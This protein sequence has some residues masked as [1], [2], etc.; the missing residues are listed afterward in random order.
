MTMRQKSCILPSLLDGSTGVELAPRSAERLSGH[1]GG[2]SGQRLRTERPAV[3]PP[4]QGQRARALLVGLHTGE[5]RTARALLDRRA[6]A[7]P[8]GGGPGPR[9]APSSATVT[10]TVAVADSIPDVLA[11][12][13][14]LDPAASDACTSPCIWWW[15]WP[16]VSCVFLAFVIVL[17]APQAERLAQI[18]LLQAW[19]RGL[20]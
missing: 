2:G 13:G 17:V 7:E 14:Q 1:Q 5:V 20:A 19:R 3:L 6:Q 10:L 11:G 8:G 18:A 16:R 9:P 4:A 12:S 15:R